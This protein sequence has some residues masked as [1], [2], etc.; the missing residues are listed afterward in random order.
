M[1]RIF[2]DFETIRIHLLERGLETEMA[3]LERIE[4]HLLKNECLQD[5]NYAEGMKRGYHECYNGTSVEEINKI[6]HH[7]R[8]PAFKALMAIKNRPTSDEIL[9][10]EVNP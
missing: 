8:H 3:A 10:K 5:M 9:L 2:E 6:I 7:R 1:S 4:C